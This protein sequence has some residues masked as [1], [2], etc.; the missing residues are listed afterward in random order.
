MK[1]NIQLIRHSLTIATENHIYCGSTDLTL[2]EKGKYLLQKYKAEN[3]YRND[4][5]IYTSN[6]I[7]VK[8]T[9]NIIYPNKKI[10]INNNLNEMDFGDYELHTYNYL[11]KNDSSYK[12]WI[13]DTTGD[14]S[15]NNGESINSFINRING[16]YSEIFAQLCN[17]HIDIATII[18]HGGTIGY[19][20]NQY[21]KFD[22]MFKMIPDP[23]LG[24][25]CTFD[26]D[27]NIRL[28]NYTKIK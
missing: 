5:V 24:Y 27:G 28:L 16:A 7:R 15:C 17:N 4:D 6:M 23:G 20:L 21:I 13:E 10:I 12:A 2:N 8:Q 22:N 14:I 26:F 18:S 11:I 3:K 25:I 1:L 9:A 19:F